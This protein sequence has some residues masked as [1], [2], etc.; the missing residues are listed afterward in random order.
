MSSLE[1][2]MAGYT[3]QL[4]HEE[5]ADS[6]R[7]LENIALSFETLFTRMIENLPII[8]NSHVICFFWHFLV[9]IARDFL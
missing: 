6:N 7:Y 2:N 3:Y 8:I 9:C 1:H 4:S 5:L